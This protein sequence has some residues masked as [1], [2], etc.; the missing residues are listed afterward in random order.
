MIEGIG[1]LVTSFRTQ[2]SLSNIHSYAPSY[3]AASAQHLDG[4]GTMVHREI[5][6][7]R[8]FLCLV[9]GLNFGGASWPCNLKLDARQAI[10][11]CI[12]YVDKDMMSPL[13][14]A[15]SQASRGPLRQDEIVSW[16][17]GRRR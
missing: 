14:L 17:G 5:N 16:H 7:A 3:L 12:N 4:I 9:T 6:K 15:G 2:F 8:S 11:L 10:T 1:Y 13:V